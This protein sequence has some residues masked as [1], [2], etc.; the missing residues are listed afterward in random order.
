ME[1]YYISVKKNKKAKKCIL[2]LDPVRMHVYKHIPSRKRGAF[3][4]ANGQG[5]RCRMTV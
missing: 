2:A 3:E 4:R 5:K 1:K